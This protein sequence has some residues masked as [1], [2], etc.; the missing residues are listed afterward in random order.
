M[1]TEP[2]MLPDPKAKTLDTINGIVDSLYQ[3]G[4]CVIENFLPDFIIQKLHAE[5]LSDWKQGK[6][7]AAGIGRRDG[8]G[9][10]Q[11]IRGDSIQWLDPRNGSQAQAFFF[12]ELENLKTGVNRQLQ[13]GLVN[14]E[15]HYAIYPPGSFYQ[16][17]L[18]QFRESDL[19]TLTCILYLNR[20]WSESDRGQLRMYLGD[21]HLDVLPEAGK[22]VCFLSS[23]FEHEVLPAERERV[24]LTTWF[25]KRA[26]DTPF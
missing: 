6:F 24:S 18:D 4:W 25:R 11:E 22:L 12:D 20:D 7:E 16:R 15:S 19:R 5:A 9:V 13:L 17:H 26:L 2:E 21:G 8:Y 1:Q 10:R 23:R 14:F 3:D